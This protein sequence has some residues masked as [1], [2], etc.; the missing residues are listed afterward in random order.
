MAAP[1][2]NGDVHSSALLDH[3]LRYPAI[4]DGVKA[5]KKNPYGQ[6]SI[7]LGEGAYKTFAAPL[8][9]YLARPYGLVSPY[10]KRADELGA[11]TLSRVDERFPAV[12]KPTGELYADAKGLVLLPYRKGVEGR[13]H[14]LKLYNSELKKNN[15]AGEAKAFPSGLVV[16]GKT[17]VA[18]A[19][20]VTG[21]T[22]DAITKFLN[23]KKEQAHEVT[24]DTREKVNSRLNSRH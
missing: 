8:L 5:F 12:K 24:R 7:S 22:F 17:L 14:V 13:D 6:R 9:S 3:L 2:V 10:V 21:E 11:K 19:L 1:Q 16:Y 15:S 23:A 20:I 4:N 18:T